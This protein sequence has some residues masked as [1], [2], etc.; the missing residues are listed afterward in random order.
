MW[1]MGQHTCHHKHR[2]A[3]ACQLATHLRCVRPR[4]ARVAPCWR[5][6]HLCRE[7]V[8]Q[9]AVNVARQHGLLVDLRGTQ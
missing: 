4:R 8:C 6:R 2:H 3:R 5:W 7:E 1:C 9:D